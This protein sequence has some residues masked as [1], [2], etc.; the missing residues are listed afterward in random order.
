M[1]PSPIPIQ[2]PAAQKAY[3][4][5]VRLS[6][7]T[8]RIDA[9]VIAEGVAPDG[10]MA[11]PDDIHTLG[12]YK[13]GPA[14][15]APAGSVVIVGHVD[16]AVAGTGTFFTLRTIADQ[17]AVQVRTA[18][19]RTHTYRVLSRQEFRKTSVPLAAIFARTGTPRLTLVTC[20][21]P[22]DRATRS[23]EDNIVVTAVPA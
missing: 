20:G 14:P 6:I 17:A 19:G 21:G 9:P 18:D 7:P 10:Q 4:A 22:F 16:S 15:G 12:W 13:W 2:S 23:Y 8:L 5:P 11:I 1:P 3:P